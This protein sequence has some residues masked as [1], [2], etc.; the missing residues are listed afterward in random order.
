MGTEVALTPP[1]AAPASDTGITSHGC[2][3][4]DVS[5][6]RTVNFVSLIFVTTAPGS[7][8]V[9]TGSGALAFVDRVVGADV[10]VEDGL[11]ASSDHTL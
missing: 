8:G 9:V 7:I 3:P 2:F 10:V 4:S 11:D 6:H 5:V 1:T